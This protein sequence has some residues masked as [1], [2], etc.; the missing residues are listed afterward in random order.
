MAAFG[1]S[2]TSGI[3]GFDH[4]F[5]IIFTNI[6]DNSFA[7]TAPWLDNTPFWPTY[8]S[9]RRARPQRHIFPHRTRERQQGVDFKT[10]QGAR[11]VWLLPEVTATRPPRGVGYP[12]WRE[13]ARRRG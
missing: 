6:R 10:P 7:S 4:P 3:A 8:D 5:V 9:Y 2:L 11:P 1:E 13:F 12:R